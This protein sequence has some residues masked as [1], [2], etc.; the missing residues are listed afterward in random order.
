MDDLDNRLISLLLDR[1]D[2]YINEFRNLDT[3]K[4]HSFAVQT[5]KFDFLNHYKESVHLPA[6]KK[7]YNEILSTSL[8]S[9]LLF[10]VAYLGPEGTFSNA[11]LLDY[12][13]NS[14]EKI[15]LKSIPD[16]FHEVEA[17]NATFGI[18]PVENSTE[19]AVTYTLDELIETD[20]NIIAEKKMRIS[21]SLLS[22]ST[23]ISSIDRVYSHPQ[24]FGQCKQWIRSNLGQADIINVESTSRAAEIASKEKGSAAIA[25]EIAAEIYDLNVLSDKIEDF[26]KN[27]TRFFIIGKNENIPSGND[28]TSI[29]CAVND[30]PS[31]LL[32]LLKPFSDA[33]I[34]MTKIESRPDKKKMWEYNFFIDFIGHKNDRFV[35]N[36]LEKMKNETVFL[37]VLG[38]YPLEH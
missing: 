24:P 4:Q 2:S 5:R 19:G 9:Q 6:L 28:K 30:K 8:S 11:A 12:F 3:E 10:K 17:G 21:F 22:K 35:V 37:K 23:D 14:V 15:S 20:L 32:Q 26:R 38:S 7:I 31:A 13:G 25:S 33:G 18:V 27:Y 16:I 34:N 36:A 29:V 1:I